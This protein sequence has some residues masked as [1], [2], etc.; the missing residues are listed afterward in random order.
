MWIGSKLIPRQESL[1]QAVEKLKEHTLEEV[2]NGQSFIEV[3]NSYT[4]YVVMLLMMA[5]GHRPVTDPFC[6]QKQWDTGLGMILIDDKVVSERHRYRLVALPDLA[7]SQIDEYQKH[8]KWLVGHLL[9][10]KQNKGLIYSVINLINNDS[11]IKKPVLPYFFYLDN[12]GGALKTRSVNASRLNKFIG[13]FWP[14]P[15]NLSRHN[16]STKLRKN[17]SVDC[18]KGLTVSVI[19]AQLGHMEGLSHPFGKNGVI[20]P[21]KLREKINESLEN[22][23]VAQGWEVIQAKRY[24]VKINNISEVEWKHE[25]GNLGPELREK[26]RVKKIEKD[27]QIVKACLDK[28]KVNEIVSNPLVVLTVRDEIIERSETDS[29]RV[30][31]RLLLL[32]KTLLKLKKIEP[33]LKLPPRL[34][35]I[36]PE[37]S[38]F[39]KDTLLSFRKACKA[40]ELFVVYLQEMGRVQSEKGIAELNPWLR[41]AEIIV[42]AALFDAV[43]NIAVLEE[44][45]KSVPNLTKEGDVIYCDVIQKH[46]DRS[47]VIWRHYPQEL[48]IGLI[49]VLR[50]E[51]N[52]NKI[53]DKKFRNELVKL[54]NKIGYGGLSA[55]ECLKALANCSN[56]YWGMYLPPYARE[57][58]NGGIIN[59]PLKEACLVRM[60]RGERLNVDLKALSELGVEKENYAML[61]AGMVKDRNNSIVNAKKFVKWLKKQIHK[62]GKKQGE[63]RKSA[64]YVRKAELARLIRNK[65]SGDHEFPSVGVA[66]ASWTVKLCENGTDLYGS[67]AYSTVSSYSRMIVNAIAILSG[68]DSFFYLSPD[69]YDYIYDVSLELN[70]H[71]D[72]T[73]F[74]NNIHDFHNFLSESKLVPELDW[75]V[76]NKKSAGGRISVNIDSSIFSLNEYF[77]ALKILNEYDE[78]GKYDSVLMK[79]YSG[80]LICG[81]R[82]GMR[83]SEAM[84]VHYRDVQYLSDFTQIVIHVVNTRFG[85]TKSAAG[86]R[87]VPLLEELSDYE[88]NIFKNIFLPLP[89]LENDEF[90]LVFGN[91][92]NPREK[93]EISKVSADL[94]LILKMVTGD[95]EAHY[96][97]LRHSFDTRIYT[98]IVSEKEI[99]DDVLF[100]KLSEGVNKNQ[101]G[102]VEYLTGSSGNPDKV[103]KALS[104][105]TG[106]SQ[107]STTIT[108]YIHSADYYIK[109]LAKEESHWKS[110]K[111]KRVDFLTSYVYR[112][113]W[114]SVAKQRKRKKVNSNDIKGTLNIFSIGIKI[115]PSGIRTTK[116][117]IQEIELM[118]EIKNKFELTLVC[119]D[120]ILLMMMAQ[121]ETS[122]TEIAEK[123]SIEEKVVREVISTYKE[124]SSLTLYESYSCN[125]GESESTRNLIPSETR[126]LR[127]LLK[128]YDDKLGV[129]TDEE[130]VKLHQGVDV[131]VSAYYPKERYVPLIFDDANSLIR[132]LEA[133]KMLG[134]GSDSFRMTYPEEKAPW[135]EVIVEIEED[136]NEDC[137]ERAS[138][139]HVLKLHNKNKSFEYS[140]HSVGEVKHIPLSLS[141]KRYSTKQRISISLDKKAK[142]SLYVQKR[143]DRLCFLLVLKL[144]IS[145]KKVVVV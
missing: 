136:R 145:M 70:S 49:H 55:N 90:A 138:K 46:K 121:G 133:M 80:L 12:H 130:K 77:G 53:S 99:F 122:C 4:S 112:K 139:R 75:A 27:N 30:N 64:S 14:F 115:D 38:P 116:S 43:T 59:R 50:S 34:H 54:M 63:H 119:I 83:I 68:R 131:W 132:F 47:N 25:S 44:I 7:I 21:L 42:S 126:S 66:L 143:L 96:H 17:I 134:I 128:E 20:P 51:Y 101:R 109:L 94:N 26:R 98:K 95:P 108:H 72:Q 41:M 11:E 13:R 3:H 79:K 29:E 65:L 120:D 71:K 135:Y 45:C 15:Y 107:F 78:A 28:Y 127:Q 39:R 104:V 88:I 92:S 111:I 106:H 86:R 61:F 48:S 36:E 57:I 140:F 82:F 6:Y 89:I 73:R 103:Y 18:V 9:S 31:I 8:L 110:L 32:W 56:S 40:R 84:S 137:D 144:L 105:M 76:F 5:T 69:E 81:Y 123:L 62:A 35:I 118:A 74:R 19:E 60:I 2:M 129:M 10:D 52:A 1:F 91:P 22:D 93:L 113:K 87:Q 37:A 97:L 125:Q 117:P 67:I 24:F 33:N 141:N 16:I 100:S 114:D 142:H 124:V 102:I 58:A 85:D 23:L